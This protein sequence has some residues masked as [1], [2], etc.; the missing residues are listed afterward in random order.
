MTSNLPCVQD[1]HPYETWGK[2]YNHFH[3]YLLLLC[4]FFVL[5][6]CRLCCP[7]PGRSNRKHLLAPINSE[8]MI[9]L[10]SGRASFMHD[11]GR[12]DMGVVEEKKKKVADKQRKEGTK[13]VQKK[14]RRWFFCL[15]TQKTATKWVHFL[16]T[17][18]SSKNLKNRENLKLYPCG[19][20]KAYKMKYL[21]NWDCFTVNRMHKLRSKWAHDT[22]ERLSLIRWGFDF[23]SANFGDRIFC[24]ASFCT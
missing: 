7:V 5:F 8:R 11:N 2:W 15:A 13:T 23:K 19:G 20:H 16:I 1:M 24:V 14:K 18:Q 10:Q 12:R 4:A 9:H 6:C 22:N 3:K 21:G 17:T